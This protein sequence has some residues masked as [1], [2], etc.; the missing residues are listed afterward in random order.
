ME[1]FKRIYKELILKGKYN[2]EYGN[3]AIEKEG[4][5]E[6]VCIDFSKYLVERMNEKGYEA[7]IIS[8]RNDDGSLHAAVVYKEDETG[9]LFIADPVTDIRMF[10]EQ[11]L[12]TNQRKE[13]AENSQNQIIDIKE[14][15][16]RFGEISLHNSNLAIAKAE[17]KSV[18]DLKVA[19]AKGLEYN[20]AG[21]N[22]FNLHK[23]TGK[24][25]DEKGYDRNGYDREGYNK[26]GFN[27]YGEHKNGTRYNDE[28]YDIYGYDEK[29]YNQRQF[30]KNGI[31]INGTQYDN[32]G[33]DSEGYD[34][35]G[36]DKGGFNRFNIHKNGT[37]YNDEGYNKYGYDRDGYDVNGFNRYAK[38]RN[39]TL[40]NEDGYDRRGRD[41]KRI[42][43]RWNTLENKNKI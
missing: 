33:Y 17:I 20:Y 23:I 28:G 26:K 9:K 38:H 7:Y 39:G 21:F 3:N 32:E 8:T 5:I 27:E 18:E 36:Y 35:K 1:K 16:T 2:E 19:I 10:T 12:D 37:E 24:Y 31:H 30:N 41:K 15:I 4:Y 40:F 13:L 14:Y 29:G 22:E 43:K 11:G 34:K 42:F 25:Y 6:G